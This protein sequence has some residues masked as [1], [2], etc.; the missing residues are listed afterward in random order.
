MSKG[1]IKR[2]IEACN[3]GT[4][5]LINMSALKPSP[6]FRLCD[7]C[8]FSPHVD[9]FKD[10]NSTVCDRCWKEMAKL[11]RKRKAKKQ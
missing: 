2:M 10:A 11:S 3:T 5:D 7:V 4:R 9:N 6:D 8:E 1:S